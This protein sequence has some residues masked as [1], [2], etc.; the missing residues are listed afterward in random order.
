[1]KARQGRFG[2]GMFVL[3]VVMPLLMTTGAL[4]QQKN[5]AVMKF[6]MTAGGG[7]SHW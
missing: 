7:H 3:L 2:A 1:M 6:T 5:L 4:A